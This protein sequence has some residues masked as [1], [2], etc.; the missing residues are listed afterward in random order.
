M[1]LVFSFVVLTSCYSDAQVVAELESRISILEQELSEKENESPTTGH[2]A[3]TTDNQQNYTLQFVGSVNSKIYHYPNCGHAK[4]IKSY[5]E[6]WF[7]SVQDAQNH[8]YRSCK[9]CKPPG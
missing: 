2:T 5:N 7:S 3:P 8:G 4:K 6:I 1:I 9:V